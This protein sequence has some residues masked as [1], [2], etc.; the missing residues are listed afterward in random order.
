MEPAPELCTLLQRFYT[1][2]AHSDASFLAQF[3]SPDPDT[4][5]IGTDPGEWWRGGEAIAQ[6]WGAAWEQRGGM[7][8]EGSQP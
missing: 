1:A 2:S 8:V 4:L 7:P 3:V 5:V 6:T